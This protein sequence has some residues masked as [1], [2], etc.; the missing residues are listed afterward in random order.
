METLLIK[1]G[2]IVTMNYKRDITKGDIF[3]ENGK[4]QFIGNNS[5][6]KADREI[7]A[8]GRVIIPGLIQT[9]VHLTQALF[10]GQGDDLELMDWLKKRIWPLEGAHDDESNYYSAK[11]GIAELIK[12]GT[13]TIVDMESVHHTDSAIN[14]IYE[15][16]IRAITGKCMMDYGD[17]LPSSIKESTEDSIEESLYLLNKWHMK[18][19]GRIRYA[20]AP[21]FVVSCTEELLIR[22]RDLAKENRVM[23]HTHASENLG[24]IE[25]VMKDRGMRNISY[26]KKIGLTGPN[27]ILAHCIWLDDDEMKILAET[28]TKVAHCPNSNLKL[29][30]GIAKIPEMM[31]MGIDV[32]IGADGSPCNNN[33]DIFNEMRTAALI[34]KARLLDS[35]VM[36]SEA[37][38]E[39]ATLGGAKAVGLEDDIGSL[40]IGKKADLVILDL[41]NIHTTPSKEVN[42]ISQI[43]YSAKS[44]DVIT[45][46]ADGKILMEDRKLLSLSEEEIKNNCNRLI[47]KQIRKSKIDKNSYTK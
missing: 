27:L 8:C 23:I 31:K 36:S 46:I 40:E 11:L 16:G 42:L 29:A 13:T 25:F 30:S 44:S 5:N 20:F 47:G 1:D 2:M 21:R 38:F 22:V 45:T 7:N 28:G 37:V 3:I 41:E 9:H 32:S 10:R 26:L 12:S 33:L 34:Q 24:E 4:I 18:D 6:I 43:V 19:N 35:T 39:L 17:D 15:S 14:A